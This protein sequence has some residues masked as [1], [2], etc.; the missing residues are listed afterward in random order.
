MPVSET[1]HLPALP[2]HRHRPS[3]NRNPPYPASSS[4]AAL[5]AVLQ[6]DGLGVTRQGCSPCSPALAQGSPFVKC[7]PPFWS[8]LFLHSPHSLHSSQTCQPHAHWG[9]WHT[10]PY[11]PRS[12]PSHSSFSAPL[13]QLWGKAQP[14][15]LSPRPRHRRPSKS[16]SGPAKAGGVREL[17]V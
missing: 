14:S 9:P 12:L 1:A 8:L 16:L 4:L 15:A 11:L 3:S 10:A 17:N 5:W 6:E 7:P 2:W 13:Q